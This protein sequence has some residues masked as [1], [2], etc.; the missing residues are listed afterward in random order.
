MGL[1]KTFFNS[2]IN[3]SV[4]F[5][6]FRVGACLLRHSLVRVRFLTVSERAAEFRR[7]KTGR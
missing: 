4:G 7:V 5:A 2:T 3:G 6:Y 1:H